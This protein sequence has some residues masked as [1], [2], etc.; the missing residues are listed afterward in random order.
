M[1]VSMIPID[2]LLVED[3]PADQ[4]LVK[5]SLTEKADSI[6]LHIANNAEEALV[7]LHSTNKSNGGMLCPDLIL[8]DLNMPGMGGKEFLK[9]IKSDEELKKIPVVVLTTSSSEKDMEDS[10]KLQAAGY[11]QKPA[12]LSDF[13]RVLQEIEDYWFL[14]CKLPRK[15][16]R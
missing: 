8:L 15:E 1:I 6:H 16:V 12:S 9:S 7:F 3:D 13:K 14:L 2:I 5:A 11:V 4:K 10:Y